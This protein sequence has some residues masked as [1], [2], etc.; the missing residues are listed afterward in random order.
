MV[1]GG[2]SFGAIAP[3]PFECFALF[4]YQKNFNDLL[5]FFN[6]AITL[7]LKQLKA[8]VKYQRTFQCHK[9]K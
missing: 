9:R 5:N 4:I 3:P 2:G 7:F 8:N 6:E 1:V